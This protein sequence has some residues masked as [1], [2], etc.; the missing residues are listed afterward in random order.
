MLANVKLHSCIPWSNTLEPSVAPSLF[1]LSFLSP[2]ARRKIPVVALIPCTG[3]QP[4]FKQS[5]DNRR[6]GWRGVR[7]S[8]KRRCDG[9]GRK[10]RRNLRLMGYR[11]IHGGS[12]PA[13]SFS[14][15]ES[16][17]ILLPFSDACRGEIGCQAN[18]FQSL[19]FHRVDLRSLVTLIVFPPS[20]KDCRPLSPSFFNVLFLTFLLVSALR[21][22]FLLLL[23]LLDLLFL[24][25]AK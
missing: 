13:V 22:C 9:D 14:H 10:R 11:Y 6:G 17:G 5:S 4:L 3:F 7:V 23:L 18:C 21:L 8:R 20:L 16:N 1:S 2:F 19:S 25:A 24:L 15:L 12:S